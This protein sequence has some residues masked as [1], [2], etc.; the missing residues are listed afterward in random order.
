MQNEKF[1]SKKEEKIFF[2]NRKKSLTNTC[3]SNIV[4]TV[5]ISTLIDWVLTENFQSGFKRPAEADARKE[6]LDGTGWEKRKDFESDYPELY[7]DRRAVRRTDYPR[8][9]LLPRYGNNSNG[10]VENTKLIKRISY[11]NSESRNPLK[12]DYTP[13]W[14]TSGSMPRSSQRII[15]F[16]RPVQMWII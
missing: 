1:Y 13:M 5:D 16:T 4:W 12:P 9:L 6:R 15:I 8:Y 11:P 3:V 10:E 14:G 7:G 2:K